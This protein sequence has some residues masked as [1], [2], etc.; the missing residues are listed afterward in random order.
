MLL[1]E[2]FKEKYEF[3]EVLVKEEGDIFQIVNNDDGKVVIDNLSLAEAV[4][5]AGKLGRNVTADYERYH[6]EELAFLNGATG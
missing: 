2:I 6:Q 5:F 3:E 1:S 4:L